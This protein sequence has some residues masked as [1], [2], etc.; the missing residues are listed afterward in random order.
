MRI[1]LALLLL[2][3]AAH[4]DVKVAK[5]AK[6]SLAVPATYTVT[7]TDDTMKGE[8]KDKEVALMVWTID[9][10]DVPAAEKKLEG[11]LYSAVA[12]MK[13]QKPTTSKVHGLAAAYVD[14]IG[15]AVGGDVDIK[16][17]LVGPTKAKKV[18]LVVLAVAHA[19]LDAHKAE[20]KAL[21]DSV[22]PAK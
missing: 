6:L 2:T 21:F 19:K 13:W 20:V 9:S 4:A 1:V 17:Q 18:L 7:V 3:A 16:A 12:S 11:E 22:Q 15:H 5:T 14:G 8:S 10:A